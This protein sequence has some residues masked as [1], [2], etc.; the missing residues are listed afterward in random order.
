MSCNSDSTVLTTR[1]SFTLANIYCL[2]NKYFLK[3]TLINSVILVFSTSPSLSP[4]LQA[5]LHSGALTSDLTDPPT[6]DLHLQD[7]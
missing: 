6:F 5:S 4:D 2:D 1:E 7:T 3:K